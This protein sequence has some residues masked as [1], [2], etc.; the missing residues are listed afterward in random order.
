MPP[1]KPD[2]TANGGED[3]LAAWRDERT[4]LKAIYDA[5]VSFPSATCTILRLAVPPD[6]ACP[7]VTGQV[8]S[9]AFWPDSVPHLAADA[10]NS[11]ESLTA[12]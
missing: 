5:D 3:Q 11:V 8:G 1:S 10:S 7:P 12:A 2:A 4:A 6:A 9:C